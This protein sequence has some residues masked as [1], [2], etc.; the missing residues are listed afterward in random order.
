MAR[1]RRQQGRM[2]AHWLYT[3][4]SSPRFSLRALGFQLPPCH[5]LTGRPELI[6]VLLREEVT[7][8]L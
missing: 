4:L 6:F 5:F 8:R 3:F 7:R 2:A 1:W